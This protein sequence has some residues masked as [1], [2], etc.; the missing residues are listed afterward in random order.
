MLV[1]ISSNGL[2]KCPECGTPRDEW[3][4]IDADA[5]YFDYNLYECPKCGTRLMDGW[6]E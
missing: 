5:G 6:I 3:V 4:L 2:E 1:P